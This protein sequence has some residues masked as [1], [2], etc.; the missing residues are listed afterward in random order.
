MTDVTGDDQKRRRCQGYEGDSDNRPDDGLTD[1][2]LVLWVWEMVV[3]IAI[4]QRCID[5]LSQSFGQ[6]L[7][8]TPPHKRSVLIRP[9]SC[10]ASFDGLQ[11]DLLADQRMLCGPSA[12]SPHMTKAPGVPPGALICLIALPIR[13]PTP[14]HRINF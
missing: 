13:R 14:G 4:G 12:P 6:S 3:L 10:T 8:P 5:H 2:P 7:I 9:S 1:G 11:P